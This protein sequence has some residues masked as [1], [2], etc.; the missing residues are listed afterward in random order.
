MQDKSTLVD[1]FGFAGFPFQ[2]R[3]EARDSDGFWWPQAQG[4]S[5]D[6]LAEVLEE[7][8]ASYQSARL[9]TY[10]GE[11]VSLPEA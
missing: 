3:V 5:Y 7:T 4:S 9:V 8:L 6:W 1:R 10:Y 11:I 2:V